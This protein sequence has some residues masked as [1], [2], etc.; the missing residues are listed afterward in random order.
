MFAL[1]TRKGKVPIAVMEKY[2]RISKGIEENW[3]NKKQV[4]A[5]NTGKVRK[6]VTNNIKG[7]KSSM[8]NPNVN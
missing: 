6:C 8:A 4:K 5:G 3:I 7:I 1:E 2:I